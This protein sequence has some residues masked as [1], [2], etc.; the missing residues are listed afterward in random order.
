MQARHTHIYYLGIGSNTE[1]DKNI[2]SC[3][4]YLKNSFVNCHSSPVYQSQSFGFNGLDFYNLVAKIH[5]VFSPHEMKKWLCMIE[6]LHGRDRTKP[7]YSNRTLDIDLLL[8]DLLTI[9]DGVI[10]IPRQEILKR[11]YVLKPLQDLAPDLVH[12]QTQKRLADLWQALNST[13]DSPL[14]LVKT[15]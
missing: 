5:S 8:C 10:Q 9:D 4:N 11:K 1:R 13:D 14:L 2:L 6:D 3:L 15:L 7:R 12:P